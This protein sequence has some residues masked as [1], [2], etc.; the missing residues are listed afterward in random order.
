MLA[1]IEARGLPSTGL[2][3]LREPEEL[4]APCSPAWSSAKVVT[5]YDEGEEPVYAIERGQHLVAAFYRNNAI[6]WFV[7]RAIVELALLWTSQQMAAR[8]RQPRAHRLDRGQADPR[9]A[10]VRVLLPRPRHLRGRAARRARPDRPGLGHVRPGAPRCAGVRRA[11]GPP[12]AAVVPR[13]PARGG[14]PAGRRRPGRSRSIEK[15]RSSTSAT[16]SV[17][18]CCSSAGCTAPSRSPAS[19]SPRRSTSRTTSACSAPARG[20]VARR[21][22][23]GVVR[24]H[25][26]FVT[27]LIER[28]QLIESLDAANRAEVTG[29]V[30]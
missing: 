21:T 30:V 17:S 27:S 15:R 25:L 23:S 4:H 1:Y 6:H 10:Q 22:C 20:R 8:V 9:P 29:V 2:E 26:E 3:R 18:R 28:A 11:D 16:G 24:E 13:R 7:N 12:G 14:R 5:V 19:C